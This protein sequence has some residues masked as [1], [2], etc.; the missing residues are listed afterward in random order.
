M[1]LIDGPKMQSAKFGGL[2]DILEGRR[3]TVRPLESSIGNAPRGTGG[4]MP[5]TGRNGRRK[6]S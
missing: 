3:V 1:I 5:Q 6:P 4:D 2:N